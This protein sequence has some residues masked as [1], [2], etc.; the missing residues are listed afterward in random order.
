MKCRI[1]HETSLRIRVHMLIPEITGHQ[2]DAMEEYIK[3]FGFIQRVRVDERT[4]N[5]I[6]EFLPGERSNV[7]RMLSAVKTEDVF[8]KAPKPD[9]GA[10]TAREIQ[11]QYEDKLFYHIAG[12]VF[13]WLFLPAGIRRVISVIKALPYA[14]EGMKELLRGRLTVPVLDATS[15]WSSVLQGDFNT[16]DN[17]IFLLKLGD[18]IEEWTHKKSVDNLARSMSVTMDK[19]WVKD[20][21]DREV[22]LPIGEVKEGDRVV[23]RAGNAIPLDGVVIE[24]EGEV[25]QA[26]MTG[27]PLPVH[28]CDG[29]YV[30]AG[31]VLEQGELLI[32]VKHTAGSGRYDRIVAMI[33]QSESLRSDTEIKARILAD[34]L[35]PYSLGA[36][37]LTYLLTRNMTRAT[38][39]LMVDFCCALK[40][41]MPIAT[42]SAMRQA[43]ETGA[44]VKGGKYLEYLAKADTIVFDKTG[45]LTESI[46]KYKGMLIF[47]E[48]EENELLRLAAC[49]EEH[50]P[51]SVAN[52]IVEEAEQRGLVH[53]EKH[54][55]VEYVVAHGI[56]SKI[57]DKRVLIGSRHFVLEDEKCELPEDFE[58]R[59]EIADASN[60][61]L[62]MALDGK[63]VAVIFIEDP[64]KEG[65]AQ[66]V[67][68]LRK[69]G[70]AKIV[71]MTGDSEKTAAYV[72]DRIGLDD[73][74]SEVLPEDKAE[75]IRKLKE[76]G[77]TV[78]MVGDGMNDACALSEADTG[79]AIVEGAAIAREIADIC[80][81]SS[82]LD[83][84]IELRRIANAL[85]ERMKKNY[86]VI[87]GFN[88]SLILLGLLGILS[89]TSTALL[90]NVS[91][92]A[93][94]L[95]CLTNLSV[96]QQEREL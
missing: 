10:K 60:S 26:S 92:I 52:A 55:K 72:A 27:E 74:C 38:S 5:V 78:I 82:D 23:V 3:Q 24:G 2:A 8:A 37:L 31:T 68:A 87:V 45:T 9:A 63:V 29:G 51:H 58:K 56:V 62:Y 46:P 13:N 42:L 94:G 57:D 71:M 85:T 16:A 6:M 54:S 75:Q 49:L 43:S 25:Q 17:V 4:G 21:T 48:E 96:E 41:S 47:G 59:T 35:V 30:Y 84:L 39:I 65:A 77:H 32:E 28:R 73:Y 12:K 79:I 89:P 93:I 76:E 1:L 70:F 90:H 81:H 95:K 19:V 91:T 14:A 40:L 69:A 34:R 33:E 11:R 18:I 80:I 22:L 53:E 50:F 64:I 66:T 15:I 7:I 86:R 67:D 61:R 44:I 20:E 36:A 83:K 88:S